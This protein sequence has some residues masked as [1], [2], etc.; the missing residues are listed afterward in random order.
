M[1]I[2]V[3]A[4]LEDSSASEDA[5]EAIDDVRENSSPTAAAASATERTV[6]QPD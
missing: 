2:T 6:A 3:S 4:A 5:C 1:S